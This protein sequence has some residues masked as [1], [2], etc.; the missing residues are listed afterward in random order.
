MKRLIV[1]RSVAILL[2]FA[3]SAGLVASAPIAGSRPNIIFILTDDQ[4]Y[5]DISAHGNPVLKTPNMDRL[6]AEGA[7]FT[8][9]HVSPTCAPTRSALMT[10]RHE[11]KNGVTHTIFERE[12]L[13]LDAITLPQVL[14][15][16]GYSTGIF[17][18]WHLGDEAKYRPEQ[19]GFDEVFIHGGGGLGQTYPGSCGDAPGNTYF[20]PAILHNGRFVRTNGFCT[21]LFFAQATQWIETVQGT[22]PFFA[23]IA[24]NAPHSPYTA[25]PEDAALYSD[26]TPSRDVAHFFGMV[27]N[28]DENIGRLLSRLD[29]LGLRENTLVIFMNDN[30]G[31]AGTRVFNAGMRAQKGTPYLGG[32]RASS[33]WRWPGKIAPRDVPVLAAHLDFFPTLTE[34]AGAKLD[35]RTAAQVEGRSLVPLLGNFAIPWGDRT[36]FTHVGRWERFSDPENAKFTNCSVRTKRWH[37]VSIKGG[38][39]PAW[40]LYDIFTDPGEKTNVASQHTEV[41]MTLAREYDAWWIVARAGMVNEKA[42]GPRL[43]PFAEL[44]WKQFGGGPDA[45]DLRIM[46]P[47]QVRIPA[48]RTNSAATV[49]APAALAEE[50]VKLFPAAGGG[51]KFSRSFEDKAKDYPAIEL[52][53]IFQLEGDEIHVYRGWKHDAAPFATLVSADDYENCVI[54][55]EYKWG[56][57]RFAPRTK[58][59]RDAGLLFFVRKP[60]QVWPPCIE[61]QIQE[62]DSGDIWSI[63]SIV[64][65]R[66]DDSKSFNP[67]S[68]P[69]LVGQN[70]DFTGINRRDVNADE[71][72]GWN[73]IRVELRDGAGK[74]FLNGKLVNSFEKAFENDGSPLKRGRIALQAEGAEITYRN[75]RVTPLH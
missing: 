35:A 57:R 71:L 36:L 45:E 37:L 49:A 75:V 31:T 29:A 1:I 20:D 43:N 10:G 55:L 53:S 67:Q 60:E 23:Y 21:D 2:G 18:K 38:V 59:K 4:G 30:G 62:T 7:R 40:E 66:L 34:I 41:V 50:V 46:E 27:H 54:E 47:S 25:R 11:F 19:R 44:Y 39:Q 13:T 24:L 42:V 28:I 17:G 16:A 72:P 73:T 61:Y 22:R 51:V 15:Q 52:E 32:T 26:N 48:E 9:F 74:Y 63:Y 65:V 12:R 68:E 3:W 5:G 56:E 64:S 70:K 33:F 69:Q 58:M 6:R 8:D 14:K